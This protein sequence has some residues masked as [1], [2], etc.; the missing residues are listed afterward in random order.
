MVLKSKENKV[1]YDYIT[2][3]NEKRI[4]RAQYDNAYKN[5]NSTKEEKEIAAESL[6]A[7]TEVVMN[8]QQEIID[9]PENYLFGKYLSLTKE[10]KV[11]NP[12]DNVEDV[13][14]WNYMSI[15]LHPL[16]YQEDLE[17]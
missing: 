2:F 4:E 17:L 8:K 9:A 12:P 1:F 7:M 6:R 14:L 15:I 10:P 11:P 5:P 3:L 13:E 16:H